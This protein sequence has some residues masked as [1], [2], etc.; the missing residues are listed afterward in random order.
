MYSFAQRSDTRVVD[1]PLYAHY[2]RVSG[3]EH[4]GREEVL[5]AMENDG[6]RVVRDL[7]LGACDRPVLF[8]KQM[9]HHL[10]EID[11][12]FLKRT[13]NVLLMRNPVEV[14]PSLAKNLSHIVL[15]DTGLAMQTELL[16]QL[17]A[18]GQEP[19]VLDAREV[20]LDPCA[21]LSCLCT[22]VGIPFEETMLEW[23]AGPHPADGVW[24]P[25][26]YHNVHRSTG[27]VS[28]CE[29]SEEFPD[30]LK[31]LLEECRPYYERLREL[32]IKASPHSEAGK[33]VS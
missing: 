27:F 2:L 3:A 5:A 28:Y 22:R 21:I 13:V 32:A 23:K 9:A 26:W 31:P 14:L 33:G 11:R 4:P 25:Y 19:T 7:I 16:D 6:A 24:A 10:V 18:W 29:K 30:R 1:E 20:L 15:R 12:D 17:R 8:M